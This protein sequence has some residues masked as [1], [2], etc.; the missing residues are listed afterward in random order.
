LSLNRPTLRLINRL[1]D[2]CPVRM[3]ASNP[4]S[5]TS[6]SRSLKSRSSCT[7]GQARIKAA[8]TGVSNMPT[9]GRLT[10]SRPLGVRLDRASS[11]SAA[12]TS[13]KIRR[14][15]SRNSRPSSVRVMLRVLRWNRR[16]SSCCSSRTTAL[17]T[18]EAERPSLR[19]AAT[20]LPVSA[21]CTKASNAVSLSMP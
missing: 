1:S 14:Q 11:A 10:R 6:T 8:I 20:K 21:D 19:P 15:R 2:G 9:S 5:T 3:T 12:S 4:S 7:S 16:T 18:A 13:S 17:P